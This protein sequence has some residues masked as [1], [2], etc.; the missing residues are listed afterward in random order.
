MSLI[1]LVILLIIV[2][3]VIWLVQ[4]LPIDGRIKQVIGA[5]LVLILILWLLGALG[6]IGT[7]AQIRVGP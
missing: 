5:V 4:M 1:S 6:V 7:G 2:G 3:L